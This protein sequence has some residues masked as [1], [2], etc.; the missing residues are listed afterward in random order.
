MGTPGRSGKR[1]YPYPV[2][3]GDAVPLQAFTREAY[4]RMRNAFYRRAEALGHRLNVS[5]RERRTILIRRVA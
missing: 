1:C 5:W 2:A 4:D 3:V